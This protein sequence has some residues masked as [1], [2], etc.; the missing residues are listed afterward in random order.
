MCVVVVVFFYF[1]DS[2]I[3]EIKREVTAEQEKDSRS[4]CK[5]TDVCTVL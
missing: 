3:G 4:V 5:G 1:A 2:E